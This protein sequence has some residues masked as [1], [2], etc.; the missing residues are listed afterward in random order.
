M[1][2]SG[3]TCAR[4]AGIPEVAAATV[5]CLRR[6]VPAAVPGVV[7]LSGGQSEEQATQHLNAMNVPGTSHPWALSFSYGRA[8]QASALRAWQGDPTRVAA[9]Q[10]AFQHRARMNGAARLGRYAPDMERTGA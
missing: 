6:T 1:V 5:A 3:Q 8:L 7:F 9:G 2:L 4:Q 10:Q